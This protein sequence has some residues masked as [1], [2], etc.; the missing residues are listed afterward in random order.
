[1]HSSLVEHP[2]HEKVTEPLLAEFGDDSQACDPAP[3]LAKTDHPQ[4]RFCPIAVE[5]ND[6]GFQ[7]DVVIEYVV[8]H[9]FGV[10]WHRDDVIDPRPVIQISKLFEVIQIRRNRKSI[11]GL[12]VYCGQPDFLKSGS[13]PRI[14]KR[15]QQN[16]WGRLITN[17]AP[18]T[19]Y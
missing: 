11:T 12:L 15:M 9:A 8:R 4:A 10:H 19:S 7:A 13:L 16:L 14:G 3:R 1:A 5:G 17:I 6:G 18:T 2:F